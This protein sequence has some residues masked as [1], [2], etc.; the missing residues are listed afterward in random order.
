MLV[1]SVDSSRQLSRPQ[2]VADS[3]ITYFQKRSS[4]VDRIL[5]RA[6]F[7]REVAAV[8]GLTN[9]LSNSD[10]TIL[11]KYLARDKQVL[12]YDKDVSIPCLCIC[13]VI[14]LSR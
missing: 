13:L 5:S 12:A 9:E 1:S 10:V 6:V 4:Q 8:L 7:G 3:M 11:L 14:D 2:E